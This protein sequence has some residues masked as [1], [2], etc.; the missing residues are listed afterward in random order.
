M[1]QKSSLLTPTGPSPPKSLLTFRW[2]RQEV[3]ML[4]MVT[5][6]IRMMVTSQMMGRVV[7][8]YS[9]NVLAT[10]CLSLSFVFSVVEH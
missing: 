9:C 10:V 4:L 5:T 7:P 2:V 3:P 1:R 8:F 6:M